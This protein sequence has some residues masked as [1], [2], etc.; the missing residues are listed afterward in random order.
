MKNDQTCI[1]TNGSGRGRAAG[2][3]F[4][5]MASFLI[6]FSCT[7]APEK[8]KKVATRDGLQVELNVLPAE[9]FYT[10]EEV[11]AKKIK[12][13]M[14]IMGGAA[15]LVLDLQGHSNRHLVVHVF[16][17]KTGKA[18]TNARVKMSFR[19]LDEKGNP[20][21]AAVEVPVVNMQMIGMGA[22]STHYG[23][24]VVM[25][26]GSYAVSVVANGRKFDFTIKLARS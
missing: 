1:V 17:A 26:D 15:P 10:K 3:Y 6:I 11:S 4:L 18:L 25:P 16:D 20:S 21:G 9:P 2:R 8:I 7:A 13:G 14:V 5:I 24:N 12:S 19:P 22:R 23:N